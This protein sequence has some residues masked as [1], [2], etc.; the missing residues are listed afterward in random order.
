M[1]VDTLHIRASILFLRPNYY[2]MSFF[3]ADN[4]AIIKMRTI[5]LIL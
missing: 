4:K 1:T 3:Y 5:F 2:I